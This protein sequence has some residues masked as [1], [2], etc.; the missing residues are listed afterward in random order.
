ML[1]IFNFFFTLVPFRK[2]ENLNF[3]EYFEAVKMEYPNTMTLFF[4]F[5][6][7]DHPR[8][9]CFSKTKVE[10]LHFFKVFKTVSILLQK[11]KTGIF[12]NAKKRNNT[13]KESIQ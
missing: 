6:M 8:M 5:N 11:K 4:Y 1:R 7:F 13:K 12:F 9:F 2:V 3:K 10:R